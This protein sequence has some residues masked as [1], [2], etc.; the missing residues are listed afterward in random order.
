VSLQAEGFDLEGI[1]LYI[2]RVLSSNQLV[3]RHVIGQHLHGY[4]DDADNLFTTWRA[5]YAENNLL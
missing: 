1:M 5:A 3:D 2:N 4:P